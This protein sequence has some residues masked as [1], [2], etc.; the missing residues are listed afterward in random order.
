M[1]VCSS[2]QREG[3][4]IIPAIHI[5]T[6]EGILSSEPI[7]VQVMSA[8][9][10]SDMPDTLDVTLRAEVTNI[11]PYKNEPFIY[12]LTVTS[13][14]GLANV[15]MQKMN[16]EDAIIEALGTP[17]MHWKV[18][19]GKNVNIIEVNYL[20]TPLK[21]GLLKI[22]PVTIQGEIPIGNQAN[23]N[24]IFD[25]LAITQG[26]HQ[27]KAFTLSTEEIML[28]VQPPV[29]DITPWLPAKALKIEEIWD[30]SQLLQ[31]GEP[32][33]RAFKIVAEGITSSQL[34]SVNDMQSSEHFKIYAGKPELKDVDKKGTIRSVRKEQYT[35]IPQESGTL[36]LPEISF[37]W[38]DVTK[39]EKVIA[40]IPERVLHILP[41]AAGQI[42]QTSQDGASHKVQQGEKQEVTQETMAVPQKSPLLY[43]LIA[44]LAFL[45]IIAIFWV[46]TLQKKIREV[47]ASGNKKNRVKREQLPNL[48]PT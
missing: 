14:F 32:I 10:G 2:S 22:P 20:V 40:H 34:P 44:G 5:D 37:T 30:D 35:L 21:P 31:V 11:A 24:D 12:T 33:T 41:T 18:I 7:T 17:K 48:N 27:L 45:L 39:K 1:E 25:L 3:E 26:F 9:A 29:A 13:E 42:T 46:I 43:T 36:T 28:D 23:S 4:A 8:E 6:S 38:W 19:G 16:L 15:R 47:E